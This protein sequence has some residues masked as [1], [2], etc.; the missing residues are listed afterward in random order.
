M[1]VHSLRGGIGG[2]VEAGEVVERPPQIEAQPRLERQ[3]LMANGAPLSSRT[4]LSQRQ[5]NALGRAAFKQA[6]GARS[7]AI[8]AA[9]V[10][11]RSLDVQIRSLESENTLKQQAADALVNQIAQR[12]T[13]L[14]DEYERKRR[15][16]IVGTLFGAPMIG[17][18]SLIMM[19]NDDAR[20]Q[21]LNRD[22]ATAKTRQAEI[23]QQLAQ[24]RATKSSATAALEKLEEGARGLFRG[25]ALLEN[26]NAQIDIL[27][28]LRDAAQA[29]GVNLDAVL[30][31]LREAAQ[32]A[33]EAVEASRGEVREL[34]EFVFA[35]DPNA[36][37][38]AWLQD[39]LRARIRQE[40]ERAV[41]S[42]LA[43]RGISG[44]EAGL[45]R[46]RL[47]DAITSL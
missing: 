46:S 2:V 37:A 4:V 33:G 31:E 15:I 8:E 32:R 40:V 34:L 42:L 20:L 24:Y 7:A 11:I 14:S 36:A 22:L 1:H 5:P 41:D 45:L 47:I 39:T 25:S 17:F 43:A 3:D 28:E 26:L 12:Q 35:D 19:Q 6:S 29:V 44:Q 27:S 38:E 16:G 9:S 18:A 21:Q 30:V 10:V 23:G 13:E